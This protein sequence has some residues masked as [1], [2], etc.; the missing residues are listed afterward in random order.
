[1][2]MAFI[3]AACGPGEPDLV[4]GGGEAM[5]SLS[6]IDTVLGVSLEATAAGATEAELFDNDQQA[7]FGC[8]TWATF[9]H[10]D[11]GNRRTLQICA[12]AVPADEDGCYPSYDVVL[13]LV[14]EGGPDTSRA[15]LLNGSTDSPGPEDVIDAELLAYDWVGQGEGT[16]S[17]QIELSGGCFEGAPVLHSVE[18]TWSLTDRYDEIVVPTDDAGGGTGGA[19]WVPPGA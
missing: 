8:T 14:D 9:R 7:R 2:V 4:Y 13:Q 1:M 16:F 15:Y 3:L 5:L 12:E 19:W 11:A 6:P 18:A 10:Y 17:G